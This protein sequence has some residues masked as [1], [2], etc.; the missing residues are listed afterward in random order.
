MA[1]FTKRPI[2]VDAVKWYGY[3]LVDG[4]GAPIPADPRVKCAGAWPKGVTC[5]NTCQ[6]LWDFY[7]SYFYIEN[8]HH[9]PIHICPGQWI[10]TG[11]DNES[12]PITEKMLR[13]TYDPADEEAKTLFASPSS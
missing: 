1:K 3:D 10:I 8:K 9:G 4:N 11:P 5:P 2:T 6:A 7:S 12:Y 13:E